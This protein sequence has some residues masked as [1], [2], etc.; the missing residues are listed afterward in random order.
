MIFGLPLV[1]AQAV[2]TP[3]KEHAAWAPVVLHATALF[4]V[5]RKT[6]AMLYPN[7]FASTDLTFIG[8]RYKE[9]FTKPP[10]FDAHARAF[11]WDHDRWPINVIG[12]GLMGSELYMRARTC[13]FG[14]GGALAFTAGASVVW[15]YVFEG[16]GVRPSAQDLVYTPLAGL[17]LGEGR[18]QAWRAAGS[19]TNPTTRA[20]VRTLIDPFGQLERRFGSPC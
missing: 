3:A 14:W 12:H 19:F 18:Y 9:A 11:E 16:N 20:V 13:A 7:P 5:Q 2:A 6:E 15:E 10:L 17:V 8:A 1:L 4:W